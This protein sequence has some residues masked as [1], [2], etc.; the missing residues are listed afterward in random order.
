MTVATIVKAPTNAESTPSETTTPDR[1]P[2]AIPDP[3]LNAPLDPDLPIVLDPGTLPSEEDDWH[4]PYNLAHRAPRANSYRF[5]TEPFPTAPRRTP[6]RRFL[7]HLVI[8]PKGLMSA[9]IRSQAQHASRDSCLGRN[10]Q[11][12]RKGAT[13]KND[14]DAKDNPKV[15]PPAN[16]HWAFRDREG[17]LTAPSPRLWSAKIALCALEA[18]EG[19]RPLN[20]LYRWVSPPLYRVLER[21]RDQHRRGELPQAL[22]ASTDT[23]A[24]RPVRIVSA[25]CYQE[26]ANSYESVIV[27]HDGWRTRAA[28]A[29]LETDRGHWQIT[30]LRLG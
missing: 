22:Q 24:R 13:R 17:N 6:Y 19:Y 4:D 8:D 9:R 28:A 21:R 15:T 14:G 10:L 27:L 30:Q 23:K 7:H 2:N 3:G 26:G 25:R 18:V 5:R 12:W 1:N 29:R 20:Q 11:T 16:L